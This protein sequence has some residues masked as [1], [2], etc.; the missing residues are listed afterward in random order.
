MY[1]RLKQMWIYYSMELNEIK[2]S[3]GHKKKKNLKMF[4]ELIDS[5]WSL[6]WKSLN[7]ISHSGVRSVGCGLLE[8]H[9]KTSVTAELHINQDT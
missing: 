2:H 4:V 1:I 8:K 9:T 6:T 7:S 3:A 5:Q